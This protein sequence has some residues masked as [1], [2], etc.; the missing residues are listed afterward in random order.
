MKVFAWIVVALTA[1]GFA[2]S[3][4][5]DTRLAPLIGAVFLFLAMAWAT[6]RTKTASKANYE[7]AERAAR[8]NR[9]EREREAKVHAAQEERMKR[10]ESRHAPAPLPALTQR[11]ARAVIRPII[12]PEIRLLSRGSLSSRAC[13]EMQGRFAK[14]TDQLNSCL[15]APRKR[16]EDI[17]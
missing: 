1:I 5:L 17:I 11:S 8:E 2:L 13:A 15:A 3:F 9:L 6:V 14:Y 10:N 12:P 7:H 16:A 4:L